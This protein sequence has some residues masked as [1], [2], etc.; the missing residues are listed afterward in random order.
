[1]EQNKRSGYYEISSAQRRIYILNKIAGVSTIYNMPSVIRLKKHIESDVIEE[2]LKKVIARHESL[3]TAFFAKEGK[4]VQRVYDTVEFQLKHYVLGAS[5][6]MQDIVKAFVKPF[7][8]EKAPLMRAGVIENDTQQYLLIDMHHIIS[9]GKSENILMKDFYCYVEGKELLPL[10][11]QYKDCVKSEIAFRNNKT[12]MQRAKDFWVKEF[13]KVGDELQLPT[14]FP[15]QEVQ[16]FEGGRKVFVVERSW[17][18]RTVEICKTYKVTMNHFLMAVYSVMLSKLTNQDDIVIGTPIN[19]R[20]N[21]EQEQVIGLFLNTL[22]IRTYP[23]AKKSFVELLNEIKKF[24]FMAMKYQNY[25][26]DMLVQDVQFPKDLSRNPVFDVAF[27][28]NS[29]VVVDSENYENYH[30][31]DSAKVDLSIEITSSHNQ[32]RFVMEYCTKLYRPETC[33]K[34]GNI[35]LC[36]LEQVT[37]NPQIKIGDIEKLDSNEKKV[38]LYEWN[39]TEF[40]YD[41][42]LTINHLIRQTAQEKRNETALICGTESLTYTDINQKANQFASCLRSKNIG[43][44]DVIA[45]IMQPGIDMVLAILG[46]IRS[47]AAYLP[48]AGNI[49]EQRLNYI[50]EDSGCKLLVTDKMQFRIKNIYIFERS[51]LDTYSAEIEIINEPDD[52]LYVIYTSGSTGNPKGV[53]VQHK[54]VVNFRYGIDNVVYMVQHKRILLLTTIC[55]DISVLE[56]IIPLI[57]GMEVWVVKQETQNDVRYLLNYIYE[58]KIDILQFTPSRFHMLTLVSG[59][60]EKFAY[61]KTLLIGGEVFPSVLLDKVLTLHDTKTFNVYGPTETTIWSTVEEITDSQITIGKPIANTQV[62]ILDKNRKCVGVGDMGEIYIAGDGVSKGYRNNQ[63]L[64]VDKFVTNPYTGKVMYA[65]GDLGKWNL[66]GKLE[67]LGRI[68]FQVK[69][70][71]YRIEIGE[72]EQKIRKYD[73]VE[74]AVVVDYEDK[75]GNKYL[76]A[77]VTGKFEG[78]HGLKRYLETQLP[79]YMIPTFFV[80][81]D[82]IPLNVNGKVN[83]KMLPMPQE[84]KNE[85]KNTKFILSSIAMKIQEVW[86]QVLNIEEIDVDEDFFDLGGNSLLAIKADLFFEQEKISITGQNIYQ[87]RTIRKLVEF[88]DKKEDE[89][90]NK[91]MLQAKEKQSEIAL[92]AVVINE[93][94]PYNELFFESCFYNSL[95]SILKFYGC[96]ITSVLRQY[97][98]AYESKIVNEKMQ[99]SGYG[100]WNKGIIQILQKA[101]VKFHSLYKTENILSETK[102]AIDKRQPVILWI[103]CFYESY[104]KDKY[105]KEHFKHTITIYGYSEEKQVFYILEHK[106]AYNTDY[107]KIMIPYNE[108]VEC[109][110]GYIEHFMEEREDTF[111]EISICVY[112]KKLITALETEEFI[113]S[114]WKE[115][116]VERW[117]EYFVNIEFVN[118]ELADLT[119]WING[120]N[121]LINCLRIDVVKYKYHTQLKSAKERLRLWNI[122]RNSLVRSFYMERY[123]QEM[124]QKNLVQLDDIAN[125]EKTRN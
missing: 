38:V 22:A 82:E 89:K 70:R 117:K 59:W 101:G 102:W 103:D 106:N 92:D 16:Q 110:K 123:T 120:L 5:D 48:L 28:F 107:R 83:R 88:L 4:V 125:F 97:T 36:V 111:Y 73:R 85:S 8:L 24:N 84:K 49:P 63:S 99:M 58:N 67:Y 7:S 11:I 6:E 1:M 76:C 87:Y 115:E 78:F 52:L 79:E 40:D 56:M 14:D 74:N 72:V 113:D 20:R 109:Y 71:G 47:G 33:E 42:K 39:K 94:N 64:T 25:T 90:K 30:Y 3:R 62:Y 75:N 121:E 54:N 55:F 116:F 32:I 35:F 46:I 2:G 61:V 18:Q 98:M 26:L 91:E 95:F 114:N 57:L 68:D 10:S 122:F 60:E 53:M 15:R 43:R 50:L 69:V 118:V 31:S 19:A 45:I 96:D 112:E 81:L 80:K 124:H 108:L 21:S 12:Y 105:Q 93:I 66:D 65:T 104:R 9:D 44:N 41:R 23:K 29:N 119:F 86:K 77:Y 100:Y 13:E 51:E 37:L 27:L 34:F 17:S